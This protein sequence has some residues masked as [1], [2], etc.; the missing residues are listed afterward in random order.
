M[1]HAVSAYA[2]TRH[3]EVLHFAWNHDTVGNLKI[4]AGSRQIKNAFR[5]YELWVDAY[6]VRE[7]GL[8]FHIIFSEI[9][10]TDNLARFP[11]S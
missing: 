2:T 9:T 4:P 7:T 6:G 8:V 5:V 1:R 3:Q 11:G 10:P